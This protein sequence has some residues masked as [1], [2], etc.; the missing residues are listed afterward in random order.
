[1]DFAD[2][3]ADDVYVALGWAPPWLASLI[4]VAAAV[5]A[6]WL[7]HR[8]AFRLLS[9][10]V[11]GRDLFWRSLVSRGQ[12]LVRIALIVVAV[13]LAGYIAPIGQGYRDGAEHLVTA[14]IVVLIAL[15]LRGALNIWMTLHLRR[16]KLDV[17]DNLLARQHVTQMNILRRV[18]D[19]VITVLGIG[20]VLMTFDSVRHY[21]VS[22]LASAGA[23]GLIA[24]LALEP[25]LK[26]IFAGIQLALTQP[27]RIDDALIVEGEW[28]NVEE[29]NATYVVIRIW[30]WRR[31]VV[32]L[33]YFI[34]QPFQNWT[35][36][37]AA[38]IGSVLLFLDYR[39]PLEP[40]RAKVEEIVRHA[41]LGRQHRQRSGDRHLRDDDAGAHPRDRPHRA[42]RLGSALPHP[43]AGD[44]LPATRAPRGAPDVASQVGRGGGGSRALGRGRPV[45]RLI[46]WC[47]GAA[48]RSGPK[49]AKARAKP[50]PGC[51][52]ARTRHRTPRL[53]AAALAGADGARRPLRAAR[54]AGAGPRGGAPRGK[55]GRRRDLGLPA[56]RAVRGRGRLSRPGWSGWRARPTRCSSPRRPGA[57]RAGR[58]R[59]PAA[60]RA[61]GGVDRGRAH[62]P[63]RR[64]CSG[65]GR[66]ARR[67]SSSPTGCSARATGAS[68]GNATR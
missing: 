46:E 63:M 60:H 47:R 43:R 29:I 58:R 30:D 59:E 49:R 4:I 45:G 1:M 3:I 40:L 22:L 66:R 12:G 64:C 8:L 51:R 37:S 5:L 2:R 21:G 62:L 10:A 57:G 17:A 33:S 42:G 36:D 48:C 54:A 34:E 11:R 52:H 35:R 14:G 7:L 28:G 24:G 31:L 13:G 65:R 50:F 32:P 39:T 53:D 20:A 56:L 16:Y 55:P 38:L 44:R 18:A 25:L 27:I 19:V 23:A 6:A 67:S 61:G 9:E 68:S 15:A 26:N 41:A